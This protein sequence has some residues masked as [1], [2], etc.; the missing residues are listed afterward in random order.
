MLKKIIRDNKSNIAFI[1]GNGINR[2]PDSP[3][4]FSWED[5]LLKLWKKYSK[6]KQNSI[7]KG[8]S[9]IEFYDLLDI[10]LTESQSNKNVIQKEVKSIINKWTPLPHHK[11][12][13]EGIRR[14]NA[15]ILTTNFD[16]ALPRSLDLKLFK[17]DSKPFTDYY[18]W[19]SY[20]GEN[21]WNYADD[22]FGIWF[23]NGFIDYHRSIRLGLTQ[24]MGS[25][26]RARGWIHKGQD[27]ELFRGKNVYNWR[28]SKTWLHL[29][30]N[31]S[32]C[33]FGL[34]FEENEVFLRWL[35]IER[36]KY[37]RQFPLR[38]KNGW[39]VQKKRKVITE[40]EKGKRFFLERIGF[41]IVE[42]DDYPDIYE[43]PWN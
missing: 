22:G 35:L 34:A 2:Y 24:Y 11:S 19:G 10:D 25:V 7:P 41:K 29:I 9:L 15:P 14:V 16:L 13:I 6:L 37:F 32:L 30:F 31:K 3:A 4:G 36:K 28:G 27:R 39:Y 33:I 5:L 21:Q 38:T 18:P 43:K 12:I 8:L 1:I 20:Y 42:V 17:T 23:I 40:N 26:E